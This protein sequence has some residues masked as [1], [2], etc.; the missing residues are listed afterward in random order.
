M[1]STAPVSIE[2]LTTLEIDDDAAR[3][4]GRAPGPLT[5][6]RAWPRATE[7]LLLEYV[8]DRGAFVPGQWFEDADRCVHVAARTGERG[9]A[10]VRKGATTVLLQSG[11]ADR[12]LTALAAVMDR[13]GAVLLA[14]RPERRAVVRVPGAGGDRYVKVVRPGRA[15][16]VAAPTAVIARQSGPAVPACAGRGG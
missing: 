8:D 5:L 7:H 10:V 1:W 15:E 13:P 16:G 14:H 2:T 12:K 3:A 9:T 11:G 6:R 4:L